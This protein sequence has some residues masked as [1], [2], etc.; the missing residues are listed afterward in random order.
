MEEHKQELHTLIG[1][2]VILFQRYE[3][4]F[5]SLLIESLIEITADSLHNKTFFEARLLKIRKKTLGQL[6]AMY[7]EEFVQSQDQ[8]DETDSDIDIVQIRFRASIISDPIS[9][10][11]MKKKYKTL[12]D[13]RNFVIHNLISELTPHDAL[14]YKKVFTK[15]YSINQKFELD[16]KN[17]SNCHEAMFK[18][19][20]L[21]AEAIN[22]DKCFKN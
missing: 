15:L 13:D 4:T 18:A 10:D 8:I 17:L 1:K 21:I 7:L 11:E 5:K 3:Y 19:R 22:F 12:V 14:S 16:L 9:K 6:V 2:T 20:K